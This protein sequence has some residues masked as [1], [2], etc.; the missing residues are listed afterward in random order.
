M[1]RGEG[2]GPKKHRVLAVE[3]IFDVELIEDLRNLPERHVSFWQG[4]GLLTPLEL[5]LDEVLSLRYHNDGERDAISCEHPIAQCC[6]QQ[7]SSIALPPFFGK[8]LP[9][10]ISRP[11]HADRKTLLMSTC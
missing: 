1:R 8:N 3:A 10:P 5:L 9:R 4:V 7:L 2:F 11:E 6:C